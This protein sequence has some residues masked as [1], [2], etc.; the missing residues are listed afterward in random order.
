MNMNI[1]EGPCT[2][3]AQCVCGGGGGSESEMQDVTIVS[4]SHVGL[5]GGPPLLTACISPV[6]HFPGCSV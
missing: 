3:G 4:G 6:A 2:N 5:L 1:S